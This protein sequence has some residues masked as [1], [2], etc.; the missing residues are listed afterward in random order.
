MMRSS[1][2]VA[3]L[4][5]SAIVA[6]VSP[7]QGE[8]REWVIRPDGLGDAPTIQAGIDSSADGDTV[9]ALP[10]IYVENI[11]FLGKA[12]VVMGSGPEVT[13]IDG[14]SMAASCVT[15]VSGETQ[16]SV[17]I[18]F[19]LTG[20]RGWD[21]RFGGGVFVLDSEPVIEGNVIEENQARGGSSG[22]GG[23][24]YCGGSTSQGWS[25]VIRGN[26]IRDNVACT[27]GGGISVGGWMSPEIVG[28]E[29]IDNWTF[30]GDGGGIA[31]RILSDGPLIMDNVIA[32]NEAAD[33]GGGIYAGRANNA[34]TV[35]LEIVGNLIARN[36][37]RARGA[38]EFSGG[39]VWLSRADAWIHHNTIVGNEG[40]GGDGTWG[41]GITILRSGSPVIEQ[42]IIAL[43]PQGGGIRCDL[44]V[45]PT[46]RNNL[47]WENTGG[48]GNGSCTA[49]VGVD[50]NVEEDPMFCGASTGD[51]SV[52]DM[53]PAQTHPAGPLGA[54]PSPG[55]GATRTRAV[56]WGELKARF[57]A[58]SR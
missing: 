42:N 41:G 19:R 18:G 2:F 55:C 5:A 29:L 57:G 24:I 53:S 30:D 52:A 40:T 10:G 43:S 31:F 48:Q 25:P 38:V 8:G 58:S 33:H 3:F 12:I 14:S 26:M 21:S 54:I 7:R 20:G 11:D 36:L 49:W 44:G 6:L 9:R 39:G 47:V 51:Y 34:G 23:G 17:L 22:S 45:T 50:G 16:S 28:N 37:A 27:N 46:I 13:T 1:P 15:F 35:E 4:G 56:S 32:N